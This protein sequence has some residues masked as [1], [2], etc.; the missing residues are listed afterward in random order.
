LAR[1]GGPFGAFS[2]LAFGG[3]LPRP[4]ADFFFGPEQQEVT[5]TEP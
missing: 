4:V 2:G 1:F 3:M 5:D